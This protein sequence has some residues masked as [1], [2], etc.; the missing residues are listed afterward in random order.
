MFQTANSSSQLKRFS[1]Q[2]AAVFN[3][4]LGADEHAGFRSFFPPNTTMQFRLRII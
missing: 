1:Q 4:F 2:S 3:V